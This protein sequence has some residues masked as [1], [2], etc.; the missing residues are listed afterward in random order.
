MTKKLILIFLLLFSFQVNAFTLKAEVF[1]T[2]D[3]D[4]PIQKLKLMVRPNKQAY[5]YANRIEFLEFDSSCSVCMDNEEDQL[6]FSPM[7]FVPINDF[8][9]FKFSY[10][11]KNR[12]PITRNDLGDIYQVVLFDNTIKHIFY[13]EDLLPVGNEIK[14]RIIKASRGNCGRYCSTRYRALQVQEAIFK[15]QQ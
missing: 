2:E 1:V 5:Y 13:S 11:V 8:D 12:D 7:N 3:N 9:N 10:G 14:V 15:K 6:H 4:F